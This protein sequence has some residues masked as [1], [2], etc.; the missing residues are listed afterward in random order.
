[1]RTV[2]IGLASGVS[3]EE[4]LAAV[5]AV[6]PDP[7]AP[8]R[9]ATLDVRAREPG[10]V[11]AAAQRGWPLTGH[12][13]ERLRQ[14]VVPTPSPGVAARVGTPSVAEAAA[15]LG[16][17]SLVVPK[18]VHG[19]VTVALAVD[20]APTLPTGHRRPDHAD[21]P[22]GPLT[23]RPA[24]D[25][26]AATG[27]RLTGRAVVVVGGGTG[28]HRYVAGLQD[29]AAVVTVIAPRVTPALEALASAGALTWQRRSYAAGDL[30][31]AWFA[32][33]ASG[34]PAVDAAVA[35]E[36]E[37]ERVFCAS[38]DGAGSAVLPATGRIGDLVVAVHAAGREDRAPD[39]RDAVVTALSEGLLPVA[40]RPAP[41]G[42][43]VL[44]GGGPGDPG[45]ITVRGRQALASADVVLADHLAPQGL[46]ASLPPEVEIIDA[47]KLPRGRF[48]AQEHINDLL[49]TRARAGR[50][51][52]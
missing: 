44:V 19:R 51:V 27:L 8:V 30:R 43:V 46:L 14:V 36:A 24:P 6:L 37:R 35:E 13:A 12:P 45:L 25:V 4:V 22:G 31:G 7:G 34:D 20:A 42:S 38:G 11:A 52:V 9:L 29:A 23:P 41:G 40:A 32:V 2:G 5:D 47:S 49:I 18:T 33:A 1:M 26:P 21:V 10:L 28:A 3:A 17:G 48:M 15:L 39:V 16:G 50:R